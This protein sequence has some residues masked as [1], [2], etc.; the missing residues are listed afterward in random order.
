MGCIGE[1][2]GNKDDFGIKLEEAMAAAGVK[3]SYKLTN[4]KPTGTCAVCINDK[5]R[6]AECFFYQ[7]LPTSPKN[8]AGFV[9]GTL[10]SSLALLLRYY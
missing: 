8:V 2:D 1:E 9:R 6:Y 5:N 10:R 7:N 4:S 3:T